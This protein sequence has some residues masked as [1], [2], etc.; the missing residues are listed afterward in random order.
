MN[1]R[2]IPLLVL[3]AGLGLL[4]SLNTASVQATLPSAPPAPPAPFAVRGPSLG[5]VVKPAV[6]N[7]DLRTL[8]Q[9]PKDGSGSPHVI[10]LHRTPGELAALQ[11]HGAAGSAPR[12]VVDGQMPDPLIT[13]AG[14]DFQNWGA[15]WP[16]DTNGDVGPNHYIQTVNTS[17]GIFDKTTGNRLV[18]I[19][20]DDFFTGT[21]TICD[22][23]NQGDVIALYDPIA[24]RWLVADFAFTGLYTGPQYECV[25]ISQTSDPVSGG[26]YFYAVPTYDTN[27]YLADY[28]KLAVW[29][30]TYYLTDNMFGQAGGFF[31]RISALDRAKMLLG[32]AFTP[33]RLDT[34]LSGECDSLLASNL[35]GTLPPAGSPN[36]LASVVAPSTLNIWQAHVDWTHPLSST[37]TGPTQLAI[38]PFQ[39]AGSV[40]QLG[41]EEVDSL[42]FR[43]MHWLQYRNYGGHEALFANHTISAD[44]TPNGRAVPRWYEIRDPGGSPY[45][46]QQGTYDPDGLYRWMGS[47]AADKDGNIAL[48]YSVSSSSMHPAIRYAGRRNGEAL[49]QLPQAEATIINGTGSQSGGFGRWG[50][51]SAMTV[52]PTDDCT[53][54]YTQEYYITTGNNWQTRIGAFKFPAC[55]ATLGTVTGRVIN[56]VTGAGVA[57]A[58]VEIAGITETLTVQTDASGY[59][60]QTLLPDTYT[61]TAG[62]LLPGYPTSAS[63]SGVAVTAGGTTIAP[64][65]ALN[66]VPY[67]VFGSTTLNDC[68]LGGNCN[69]YPE[70]GESNLLLN[71]GLNNTGAVTATNVAGT[72]TAL[73]AGVSIQDPTAPYP[74]IPA[75]QTISNTTPFRFSVDSSVTCGTVLQFQEDVATAEGP[76]T[77]TFSLTA[78]VPQPP[79]AVFTDSVE[80]GNLGWTTGGTNNLWAITTEDSHSP[81]HSWTDS[82]GGN[83]RNNTN[84]WLESPVFDLS[85]KYT[86]QFSAWYKYQLE[87]GY[88]YVYLEYSTDGGTTWNTSDPLLTLNGTQSDWTQ[89]TV[90]APALA[91]QSQARLRWHLISDPGVTFDGIHIDDIE[92]TYTPI[93]CEPAPEV[94]QLF[95][96]LIVK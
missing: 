20:Y 50:D 77:T 65:I 29:P 47:I 53:F 83:Y 33:I 59:Y 30:D 81:T 95:L 96:P 62:P 21:G 11:S 38:E 74:S 8:P 42:S 45:I 36:Y 44:G 57:G 63:V 18:G 43:L 51:Y 92:L 89:I 3:L 9:L 49:G 87:S 16:P 94:H 46:Y 40:P 66:P 35:R 60:T 4:L 82:P 75:G 5:P 80:N 1:R 79:T 68:G 7:G 90:N 32:Q 2:H 86:I 56:A 13:F 41:G 27:G 15:G 31:V 93:V 19:T 28:P 37:L 10:P 55:G 12:S 34:C 52:D 91:N 88:D 6:F 48:G 25:A 72:L 67:L 61:I 22:N 71:V 73:T 64:D 58:P 78:S 17:I 69:G 26:W 24:D 84:S 85:G 54:W 14:L 70:P 23:S 39:P 76:F